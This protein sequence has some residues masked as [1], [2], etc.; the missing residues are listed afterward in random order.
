MWDWISK[1][2]KNLAELKAPL[3]QVV[4]WD[5]LANGSYDFNYSSNIF[6][7]SLWESDKK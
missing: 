4:F 2:E 1:F 3:Y 6:F 7:K 5:L